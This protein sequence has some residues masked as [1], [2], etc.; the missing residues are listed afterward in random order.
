MYRDLV[1]LAQ[2]E[3]D[4]ALAA[5]LQAIGE[6]PYR[7]L[8]W[9]NARVMLLCERLY[10]PYTP[11]EGYPARGEVAGLDPFGVLGSEYGLIDKA[12]VLR[13]LSGTFEQLYPQLYDQDLRERVPRSR[14]ARFCTWT[15][16]PSWRRAEASG[17]AQRPDARVVRPPRGAFQA[18]GHLRRCWPFGR[19]RAG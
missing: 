14:G 11:S 5:T 12:N 10:A 19:L 9:A 17:G 4:A 6:P 16:P 18:S 13:G 3:D 8:P 7:D 1:A 15:V 2:R